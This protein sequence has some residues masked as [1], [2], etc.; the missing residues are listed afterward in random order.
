[1]LPSLRNLIIRAE[2]C[3]ISQPSW[4]KQNQTLKQKKK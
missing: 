3:Y 4:E 2:N 1:M